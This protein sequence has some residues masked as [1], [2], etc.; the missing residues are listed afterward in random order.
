MPLRSLLALLLLA[1]CGLVDVSFEGKPCSSEHACPGALLCDTS[2]SICVKALDPPCDEAG[3]WSTCDDWDLKTFQSERYY[4]RN[5][6]WGAQAPGYVA[7][8]CVW[9]KSESCWGASS[10]HNAGTKLPKGYPQVV[11][12]YAVS[13]RFKF[14]NHG[15]AIRLSALNHARGRWKMTAP[16]TGSYVARW[17]IYLHDTATPDQNSQRI[18]F[19]EQRATNNDGE[20]PAKLASALNL[21]VDGITYAVLDQGQILE[22]YVAPF[23]GAMYGVEDMTL[24]VKALLDALV[25]KGLLSSDLFLNGVQAGWEVTAGGKFR[26]DVF[27][28]AVQD[29]LDR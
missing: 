16:T 13:D 23:S 24:D 26:S 18:V 25:A 17:A 1:G 20:L 3:A 7:P 5:N 27:W 15:L 10:M 29:E 4:V 9:A 14:P 6:V 11:R 12:G 19:V 21:T 28:F 8:Q 22:L 2:R